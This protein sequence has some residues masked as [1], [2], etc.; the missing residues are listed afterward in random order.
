M[1][2]IASKA[3]I[4]YQDELWIGQYPSG[5]TG[6]PTFTQ[7]LGVETV[8]MPEKIPE[9]VDVT[10]MQSPGRSRETMP[11]LLP[12]G[13]LSQEMQFWP[14]DP[15]QI[16]V[17]E[18]ATLTEA[19]TREIVLLEMVVGG[20]R[21]TYRSYVT[22]YT[23]SGKFVIG[24]AINLAIGAVT[25]RLNQPKGPKPRD[26]QTEIRSGS[27]E[28]SQHFGRVRVGGS[29]MFASY[30]YVG[31][32]RRA[33]VLLAIATGGITGV[34]Q[35][36]LD[37]KPVSVNGDGYVTTP[38]W[39]GNRIRLRVRTGAGADIF[40]GAWEELYDTFP[41]RWRR[42]VHQL[43]GVATILGEF[44]AVDPEQVS[45]VYPGGRPPEITATIRGAACYEPATGNASFTVNPI[46]HLLHYLSDA[47]VG[48]IPLAEF[49]I[50]SWLDAIADCN[51]QLPTL[52]GTRNRYEGGGSYLMNEPV[53]DVAGRILEG[54]GGRLHLTSDGLIGVR[55]AKWRP[56]TYVITDDHIVRMACEPGR[57]QLD[58]VTTLVPEYVEPALDYTETTADPWE[59]ATAIARYGEPRPRELSLLTVQHHG[60]ARALAK[61]AAAR[62]NPGITSNLSLRFWGLLLIG[63]E[64][65]FVDRPDRGLTMTPM[66]IVG[67][68]LDLTASDGVVKLELESDYPATYAWAQGE[69][70]AA[71]TV[72]PQVTVG[73]PPI[74]APVISGVQ[75]RTENNRPP[76]YIEGTV[77]PQVSYT[78]RA[79]FRPSG[80]SWSPLAVNAETGYFRTPEL[81]D[82][83]T[84]D[85]RARRVL[86]GLSAIVDAIAGD[87]TR[88]GPWSVVAGIDVIANNTAPDAPQLVSA[89]RAGNTI[90]IV[91]RP[92]LGANYAATG[93]FR[94]SPFADAVL[95]RQVFDQASQVTANIAATPGAQTY[96]IRSGNGSGVTSAP[97][98]IGSY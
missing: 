81:A 88:F 52:G 28:R 6:T 67:M 57:S 92:G 58:R 43:H 83:A 2:E 11:G 86:S 40:G 55:V 1:V 96:W 31:D 87:T 16:I 15:G 68:A 8:G 84:Y 32:Q 85:I 74:L 97:V 7:I 61:I 37:G 60:Q 71:P 17:D 70:G 65:V 35:W 29:L 50:P 76:A 79:Q 82:G 95:V 69:E 80:G 41:G 5:G 78:G 13:D 26:L 47:G 77:A 89:D 34:D 3:D 72:P 38:P 25:A 98:N 14:T 54:C 56:P 44:D 75:V 19:G 53:K 12:V 20:M 73:R 63:E 46:R 49:D 91:F 24:A 45:D 10:H 4:G 9:D 62:E 66:R 90:T 94:G 18:M 27:A 30:S 42:G 48:N 21:R 64:R 93:I 59:N 23:P 51:D 33:F 36:Y 39:D 22:S